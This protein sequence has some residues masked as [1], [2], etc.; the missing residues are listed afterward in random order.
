MRDNQASEVIA[1]EELRHL[2]MEMV[3]RQIIARGIQDPLVLEAMARVP[4]HDY[5]QLGQE[6]HAY[7]DGPLSIGAGQTIS[8]PYVVALMTEMAQI[9]SRSKVLEVGTGSGYQTAILAEIASEV[10]TVEVLPQLASEARKRL[11]TAGYQNIHFRVGDGHHGWPEAAPFDAIVVTAAPDTLP[12]K[13]VDQLN[14]KGRLVIPI[15]SI[16]QDLVLFRK[17]ADGTLKEKSIPV[18]FVPMI[19][20]D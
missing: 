17:T 14:T 4:R 11:E 5:V 3:N 8:Q 16:F 9:H 18:R 6:R 7:E 13:L 12:Q 2:R 15:G 20:Q 10:F 19:H 1:L